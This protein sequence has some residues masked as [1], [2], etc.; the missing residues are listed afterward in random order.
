[1]SKLAGPHLEL[2]IRFGR[3]KRDCDG[4]SICA[5]LYLVF[6]S[7]SDFSP[8]TLGFNLNARILTLTFLHK[9]VEVAQPKKLSYLADKKFVTFEEEWEIPDEIQSALGD[10]APTVVA[11]GEYPI[12]FNNGYY[13]IFM[14]V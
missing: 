2:S 13:S 4:F 12:I 9:D 1:M 3:K 11:A 7:K 10:A 14:P 5:S 8:A 6:R